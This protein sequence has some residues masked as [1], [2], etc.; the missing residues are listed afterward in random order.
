M[1]DIDSEYLA[2]VRHRKVARN[3]RKVGNGIKIR[4]AHAAFLTGNSDSLMYV[5]SSDT[6]VVPSCRIPA[7]SAASACPD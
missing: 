2:V 1:L 3:A 4:F 5:L 7:T 6:V